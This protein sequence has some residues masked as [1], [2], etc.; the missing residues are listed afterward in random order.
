[1][2][3]ITNVDAQLVRYIQHGA[4]TAPNVAASSVTFPS[5]DSAQKNDSYK[6]N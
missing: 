1:M 3:F 2:L 4:A 5:D 6:P